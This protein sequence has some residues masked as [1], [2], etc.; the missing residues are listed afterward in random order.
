MTFL[1]SQYAEMDELLFFASIGMTI[2][3]SAIS[4]GH[5]IDE[6]TQQS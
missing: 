2:Y 1:P 6:S 3:L 5:A 4:C